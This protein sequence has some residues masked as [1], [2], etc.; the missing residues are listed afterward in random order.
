MSDFQFEPVVIDK[1]TTL[2][3]PWEDRSDLFLW[4]YNYAF[5]I[6]LLEWFR[7]KI[8]KDEDILTVQSLFKWS[9]L[10]SSYMK[11][12]C[13]HFEKE[14]YVEMLADYIFDELE[15]RVLEKWLMNQ[16]NSSMT[17]FYLKNKFNW[18]DKVEVDN[19]NINAKAE[20]ISDEQKRMIA[21]RYTIKQ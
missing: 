21:E 16:T 9:W 3:E 10:S 5:A 13:K 20:D 6:N 8:D 17:Q 2:R 14:P 12:L 4:K 18:K 11:R 1:D 7:D 15:A 19:L